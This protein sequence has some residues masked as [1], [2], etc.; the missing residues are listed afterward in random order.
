MTE[1]Y[2][3]QETLDKFD[4][5]YRV[6]F[7]NALSG[8]KSANLIGTQSEAGVNNLALFS[9]AVHLGASPSLMG[10]VFR[11]DSVP[12][13]TLTNIRHSGVFTVN[14]VTHD[15]FKQAHQTSARYKDCESEFS[16]CDLAPEFVDDFFAPAVAQSNIKMGF[17]LVEELPIKANGTTFLVAQMLWVK[18]PESI[19][20]DDGYVDIEAAD[21]IAVSGLDSYHDSKRLDRLAYAKP[22]VAAKPIG[23]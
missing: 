21:T 22:F 6:N 13:D 1:L 15:I 7:I 10:F 18:L 17:K 16:A 23:S 8:F 3:D 5:R 4:H 20:A 9:S 2:V 11:P 12:R 14:H 19:I